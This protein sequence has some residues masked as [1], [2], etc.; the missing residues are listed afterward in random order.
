MC[1]AANVLRHFPLSV[2]L[3]YFSFEL[4]QGMT[5][6]SLSGVGTGNFSISSATSAKRRF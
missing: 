3:R 4:V 1:I 6:V 2:L 5:A